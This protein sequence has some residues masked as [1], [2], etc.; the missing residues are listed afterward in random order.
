MN[1][2]YED[3][4]GDGY[5]YDYDYG[6]SSIEACAQ[7]SGYAA[8]NT[9]CNDNDP[10]INPGAI[11]VCNGIDDDCNPATMDSADFYVSSVSAPVSANAGDTITVTDTTNK[12]GCSA[13]AST[14]R[15]YLSKY[16]SGYGGIE[17]GSGRIAPA[18][19]SNPGAQTNSGSISGTIPF[20]GCTGSCYIV[21]KADAGG[22]IAEWNEGNNKR[23]TAI[24]I[25]P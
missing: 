10:T 18:F 19:T 5:G 21:V 16:S 22:A 8:D 7:P 3:V 6:M 12:S 2:Y 17:I 1:T 20:G 14:T 13:G 24:T 4:D 25:G 9:D 15:I 11:E 23:A